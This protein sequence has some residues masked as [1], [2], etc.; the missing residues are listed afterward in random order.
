MVVLAAGVRQGCNKGFRAA[1]SFDEAL[2]ESISIPFELSP[3]KDWGGLAD[4]A[5]VE[6]RVP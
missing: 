3:D 1:A 2:G 4:R 5:G 6:V